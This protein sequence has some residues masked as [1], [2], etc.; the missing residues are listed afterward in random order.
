MKEPETLYK[1]SVKGN[2]SDD[3]LKEFIDKDLR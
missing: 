1:I 2:L 3:G